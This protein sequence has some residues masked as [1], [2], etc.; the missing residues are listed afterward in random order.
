M[1]YLTIFLTLLVSGNAFMHAQEIP[2]KTG[3]NLPASKEA[4]TLSLNLNPL[5][6]DVALREQDTVKIDS[7]K[8]PPE[9]LTDVVEYYGEDYVL[10]NRKENKVY[11][12][13]KAF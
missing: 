2:V 9:M 5:L 8:P 11:M 13:N 4:D 3:A 7:I 6:S 10:L 12:Y 1:H